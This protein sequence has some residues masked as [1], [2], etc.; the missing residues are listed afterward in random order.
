MN[1]PPITVLIVTYDRP[2]EIREVIE[3]LQVKLTYA[4]D[5]HWHLAD[6]CSPTP[7]YVPAILSDFAHLNFTSTTTP[8]RRGWG[9]NVNTGLRAIE[10]PYVFQCEDDQ[11]ARRPIDLERGVFVMEHVPDVGLVRYDGLEGHRLVLHVD[12]TPMVDGRR[13]HFLRIDKRSSLRRKEPYG[14]SNR[15]HLKHRRFHGSYRGYPEGLKLGATEMMYA[16]HVMNQDGM[17]ELVALADGIERAF[18]H[19]GRSRQLSPEDIG[20]V[21]EY[22]Q[23]MTAPDPRPSGC[24]G[25]GKKK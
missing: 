15:P 18:N 2:K 3:A 9:V 23:T 13:V 24:A 7:G 4:G 10:T 19:I 21:I 8:Q 6:D 25:C 11:V 22:Q 5:L 17:P 1:W 12:E 20:D 14:Y 16:H